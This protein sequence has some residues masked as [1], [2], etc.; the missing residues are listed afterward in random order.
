MER[1]GEAEDGRRTDLLRRATG[2]AGASRAPARDE[3]QPGERILAQVCDH[4][5][6]GLVELARRRRA[7]PA[8]D[9]VGLL[10]ERDGQPR[11]LGAAGRTDEVRRLD[12]ATRA[13]AEDERGH[14]GLGGAEMHAR[15]SVRGV[16][17]E[18]PASVAPTADNEDVSSGAGEHRVFRVGG[19]SYLR[20]PAEDPQ[21][22]AAFYQAVFGWSVRAGEREPAF[23][24]GSGHVIGHFVSDLSV[25]GEAGVRPYVFVE[26]VDET[27]REV[28]AGGGEVETAPYPE[29]DLWV[30]TFRDPSG[31]VVGVWQQGPRETS[32]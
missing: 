18:D 25:A 24:D 28:V 12:A 14:G 1:E 6:P 4:G 13:V 31:N 29:G 22:S 15:E 8:G 17:L 16:E 32:D 27:L 19:I 23:E 11:G 21:R 7:A 2:D 26:S 9:A 5:D 20:I 10:D 3:R 30:A